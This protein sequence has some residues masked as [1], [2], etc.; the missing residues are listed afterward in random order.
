LN[1]DGAKKAKGS[2]LKVQG[3]ERRRKMDDGRGT[4]NEKR[5]G[6]IRAVRALKVYRNGKES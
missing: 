2:G 1:A 4:M 3:R 6:K 5:M